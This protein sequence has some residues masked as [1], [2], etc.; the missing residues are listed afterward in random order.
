[1]QG[2]ALASMI[3]KAASYLPVHRLK[4]HTEVV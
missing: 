3:M 1:M 2:Q 4:T